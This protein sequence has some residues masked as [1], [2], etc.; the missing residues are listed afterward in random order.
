MDDKLIPG[1]R[2][3]IAEK[4]AAGGTELLLRPL[5]KDIFLFDT[6]IAGA[7]RLSGQDLEALREGEELTLLRGESRFDELEILVR[8]A[9][10]KKLGTIPEKDGPV[11]ARLMDAGKLLV[12]KV[13]GVTNRNGLPMVAI[14]IYLR[15][16]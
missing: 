7:G 16:F 1:T 2:T 4:L 9:E 8:T 3:A 11:F 6:W 5:A 14:G 13:R 10:G 12:A 15:D